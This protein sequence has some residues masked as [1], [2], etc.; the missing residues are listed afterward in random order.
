MQL[1]EHG[2]NSKQD[3]DY[4][5][6]VLRLFRQKISGTDYISASE[7]E[8]ITTF[9]PTILESYLDLKQARTHKVACRKL[10]SVI[11]HLVENCLSKTLWDLDNPDTM[12]KQ[13]LQIGTNLENMLNANIIADQDDLNDLV[14]ILVDRFI[15]VLDLAG[16]DLPTAFYDNLKKQLDNTS[17]MKLP[18]IEDLVDTKLQ[19]IERAFLKNKIKAHANEKFGIL[20]GQHGFN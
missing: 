8:R 10:K 17:W 13:F 19:K 3:H 11:V 4:I 6:A 7:T 15:Y 9:I 20:G 14:H 1:L 12:A 18:E 5:L 2:K 16:A